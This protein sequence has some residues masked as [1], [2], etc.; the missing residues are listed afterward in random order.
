MST[1]IKIELSQEAEATLRK[2]EGLP[3][4]MLWAIAAAMKFENALTVSHIREAYLNFPKQGPTVPIGCR[5][6]TKRMRQ[7][8]WA[9]DPV[10]SG[11][12]VQSA[13]GNNAVSKT[14]VC[15]P[16]VHEFGATI[17]AHKITASGKAL[18]FKIGE[19][20]IFRKS[21]NI[22]EVTLP[23]RAPIQRGISDRLS[24][25]SQGISEAIAAGWRAN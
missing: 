16:A 22:P 24:D 1:E 9:S 21:V 25:Y 4:E 11:Q 19:R 23:A 10:I 7:S 15:Y 13:I 8:L 17:P 12:V 3:Q 2:S 6:V 20:I 5:A 18:R 14:G